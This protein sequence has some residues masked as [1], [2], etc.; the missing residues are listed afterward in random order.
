MYGQ[1]PEILIHYALTVNI[2]QKPI[3]GCQRI[4]SPLRLPVPPPGRVAAIFR[5]ILI[6]AKIRPTFPPPV[7]RARYFVEVVRLTRMVSIGRLLVRQ[8]VGRPGR[9]AVGRITIPGF[10]QVDLI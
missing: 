7:I 5:R 8:L 4:L 9:A 6:E 2:R 1:L 10:V 3:Y